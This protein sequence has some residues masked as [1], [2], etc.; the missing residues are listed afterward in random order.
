V[1]DWPDWSPIGDRIV[2][3]HLD[4]VTTSAS[5]WIMNADGTNARSLV[6]FPEEHVMLAAPKWSRDGQRIAFGAS[7]TVGTA[8]VNGIWVI[9]ADGTDLRQ[10]TT[11]QTG[12]DQLPSWSPDG[13]RIAF[14]RAYGGDWDISII[15]VAT[16]NVTRIPLPGNQSFPAWSPDGNLIAFTQPYPGASLSAVYTMRPDGGAIRLRTTKKV[17]GGGTAPAWIVRN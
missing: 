13:K 14:V 11:T 5:V 4:A 17:L 15:D 8:T 2:Y 6:S 3:R 10:L 12:F 1:D 7:R 16:S 9:N